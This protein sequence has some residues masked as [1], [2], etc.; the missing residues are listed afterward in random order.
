MIF[1]E[2]YETLINVENAVILMSYTPMENFL[3]SNWDSF[4]FPKKIMNSD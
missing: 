2:M 3:E 1:F 4:G